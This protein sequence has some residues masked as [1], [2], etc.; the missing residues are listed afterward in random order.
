[1]TYPSIYCEMDCK[2]LKMGMAKWYELFKQVD[3]RI[4]VYNFFSLPSLADYYWRITGC[5][6]GC[7]QM[8]G[9]LGAFFQNFV[10]G[11][12]VMTRKKKR[13]KAEGNIQDSDAVSFVRVCD[14]LVPRMFEGSP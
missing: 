1:M 12:R 2:V 6:D 11:G 5:Y 9:A 14:A 4:D 10:N 3:D 7:M 8:N 13:Q